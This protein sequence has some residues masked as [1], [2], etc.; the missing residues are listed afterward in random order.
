MIS[1][2]LS[3]WGRQGIPKYLKGECRWGDPEVLGDGT[4]VFPLSGHPLIDGFER[5][6]DGVTFVPL[7][8]E[9]VYAVNGLG[10]RNRRKVTSSRNCMNCEHPLFGQI[11]KYGDCENCKLV[12]LLKDCDFD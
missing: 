2:Q 1:V 4:L 9:C 10:L 8:P 5:Q 6:P 11:I 12:K 7:W 3:T